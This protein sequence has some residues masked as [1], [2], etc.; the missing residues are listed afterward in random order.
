[1]AGNKNSGRRPLYVKKWSFLLP[2]QVAAIKQLTEHGHSYQDV[3]RSVVAAGLQAKE[4]CCVC[5]ATGDACTAKCKC[6]D[7]EAYRK[8]SKRA[9]C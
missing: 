2:E 4:V 3:L 5:G 7:C 9:R 6:D 1:M 8:S